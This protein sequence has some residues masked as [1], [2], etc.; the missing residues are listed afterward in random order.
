MTPAKQ[1]QFVKDLIRNIQGGMLTDLP[2]VPE[3]W[4]GHELRQWIADR[5]R[6]QISIPLEGKRKRDY[7]NAIL[8]NNL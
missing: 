6:N 7:K 5:F 8:V 3:E 4:D 2:R 1:K